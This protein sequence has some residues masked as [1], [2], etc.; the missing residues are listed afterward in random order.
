L[1]TAIADVSGRRIIVDSSKYP[2][3]ALALC[4]IPG[5][6][7]R[8]IHLVR[9]GRAVIWSWR[10]KANTDLQG[11]VYELD[12]ARVAR[13][14]TNSW[15]QSNLYTGF[16][17]RVARGPSILLRYEDLV[18]DPR[19]ALERVGRLA[20]IDYSEV[21]DRLED[22]RELRVGHPV[23]GNRVRHAGAVRLRPDLEWREKLAE[24][25]RREFWKRAGW[26]AR[27]YGYLES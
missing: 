23:A 15:L 25:D 19:G 7:A 24:G 12:A 13:M 16:A 22:G 9:D 10:R 14:T 8:I 17:R 20:G 27:R 11:N 18:A 4:R 1:Y 26:L 3:R 5:L 2:G 21:A 6:D